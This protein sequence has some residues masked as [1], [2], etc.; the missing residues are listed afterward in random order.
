MRPY[1]EKISLSSSV[2]EAYLPSTTEIASKVFILSS[3]SSK[4]KQQ[5]LKKIAKKTRFLPYYDPSIKTSMKGKKKRG[6]KARA[7]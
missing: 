3:E 1:S 5:I 4:K 2:L 6:Q 7:E